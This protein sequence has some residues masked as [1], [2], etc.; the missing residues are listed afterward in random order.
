MFSGLVEQTATVVGAQQ[1][2]GFL[3]L[4]LQ[5]ERMWQDAALGESIAVNGVCLTVSRVAKA[6]FDV[7]L[8]PETLAVTSARWQEGARVNVERA[9]LFNSRL[10]GHL[11]S[12]HV[13]GV[14]TIR[15]LSYESGALTALVEAP[16]ALARYLVPKGSICVDGVSL[17]VVKVG[18]AA[19]NAPAFAKNHFQLVIVPHTLKVTIVESW[20]VGSQVNLEVDLIAKYLERLGQAYGLGEGLQ[21][22]VA[23]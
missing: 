23:L 6:H 9:L 13:D 17:T 16:L 21:K 11:V 19:G 18:G 14:G 2:G 20:Q 22:E 5:P 4:R 8:S 12:G 7:E 15:Q 3:R 1:E 10:G